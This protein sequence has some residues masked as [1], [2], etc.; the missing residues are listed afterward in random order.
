MK[1]TPDGFNLGPSKGLE[2][3][4]LLALAS[5]GQI[6]Y[7]SPLKSN[8]DDLLLKEMIPSNKKLLFA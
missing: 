6:S 2:E 7:K 8:E 4:E 3:S 5:I 1:Y